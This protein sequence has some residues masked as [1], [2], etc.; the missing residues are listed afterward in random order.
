MIVLNES[1]PKYEILDGMF[2]PLVS[3]VKFSNEI[4]FIIDLKDVLR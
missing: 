4:T 1:K 2:A 3:S